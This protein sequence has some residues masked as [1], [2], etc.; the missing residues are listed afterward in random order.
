MAANVY[1]LRKEA[2][3]LFGFRP[4]L[5]LEWDPQRNT[6]KKTR[7]ETEKRGET[8]NENTVKETVIKIVTKT[9]IK[10][11]GEGKR[12]QKRSEVIQ[13]RTMKE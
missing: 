11:G 13:Q 12:E 2:N 7:I 10:K 4:S 6:K 1:A 9:R 3:L 5:D 8:G